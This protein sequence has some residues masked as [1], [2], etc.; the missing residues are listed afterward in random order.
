MMYFDPSTAAILEQGTHELPAN[1][2]RLRPARLASIVQG[3]ADGAELVADARGKPHLR[4][5]DA[6][7]RRTA[8]LAAVRA[9]AARRI[10]A[11]SPIWRQIND[12]RSDITIEA[13]ER[14]AAIDAIREA[15]NLI[16]RD[17]ADSDAKALADFP[18]ATHP[19]WPET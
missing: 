8:A 3:M 10:H 13:R 4:W 17:V 11:V 16:E 15:S 19:L 1:A 14:W 2:I 6:N 18:V 5:P 12:L 7:Q 9:E